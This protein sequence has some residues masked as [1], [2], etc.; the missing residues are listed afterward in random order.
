MPGEGE[1][2]LVE[3]RLP[4]REVGDPDADRDSSATA[5]AARSPSAHD[6]DRAAGRIQVDRVERLRQDALGLRSLVGVEQAHVQRAGADGGLELARRALGDHLAV[7]D[8]GDAVGELVRLVEVLG[9][10]QDRGA[11]GHSAP[12]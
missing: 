1:E 6:A 5:W 8:D 4:Q 9:A 11:L 10:E 3:A 2:D 12:G 7:V